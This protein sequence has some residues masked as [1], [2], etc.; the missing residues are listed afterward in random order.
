[1]FMIACGLWFSVC[2]ELEIVLKLMVTRS[3]IQLHV[4][5][6]FWVSTLRTYSPTIFCLIGNWQMKMDEKVALLIHA[7]IS[8][9]PKNTHTLCQHGNSAFMWSLNDRNIINFTQI[10]VENIQ[11]VTQ[12]ISTDRFLVWDVFFIIIII[13]K[14]HV[15]HF[16]TP[17]IHFFFVLHAFTNML[18][19]FCAH[20]C[21]HGCEL[22]WFTFRHFIVNFIM[23]DHSR[24]TETVKSSTYWYICTVGIYKPYM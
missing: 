8:N 1:M 11:H 2:S 21:W 7:Y 24:I 15:S 6:F 12:S 23:K 17:V 18:L 22:C 14:R 19:K 13:L 16:W 4:L 20:V 5:K 10:N 9:F 3:I